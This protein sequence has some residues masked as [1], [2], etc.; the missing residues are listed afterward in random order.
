M[1]VTTQALTQATELTSQ[2]TQFG[3][4][5]I[6]YAKLYGPDILG[7]IVV[8]F[9]W[10]KVIKFINKLV[11]KGLTTAH[12]DESLH[13]FIKS[14]V[15]T[16]LKV[17][18][19]VSV[20]GMVG[21]QTTSF[22]AILWAAWLAVGL[23]LQWSLSNFAAGVMILLFKPYK[24]GD[25]AE[26]ND[27][28]GTVDSIDIFTTHI[29]SPSNRRIIIPNST[30]ISNN[31]TNYSTQQSVRVDI[32][33]GIAYDADLTLAKQVLKQLL[34]N[35]ELLITDHPGTGVFVS[36]L[37]D[38]SVNLIV[39]WYANS[40]KYRDAYFTLI[41][42]TKLTLDKHNIEIPFP[43]RVVHTAK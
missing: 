35:E 1:E 38:S 30:I 22:V 8:L 41:E 10:F 17:M 34:D 31:I 29:L 36:E 43:Q 4:L 27:E 20:A 23:A 16:L 28:M 12:I 37:A 7:A 18:L 25:F 15:S 32:N 2:A 3:Q 11:A 14:I 39:R 21:I 9:I 24:V 19:L 26:L 33:V 6:D 42:Q 40:G 13:R 5:L